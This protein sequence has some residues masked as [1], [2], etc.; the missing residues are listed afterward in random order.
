[1]TNEEFAAIRRDF[2]LSQEKMARKLKVST[3]TI[4]KWEAAPS[5][6]YHQPISDLAAAGIRSIFGIKKDDKQ[7]A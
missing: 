4:Q 2:G 5:T 7:A 6:S 3:S 1:M